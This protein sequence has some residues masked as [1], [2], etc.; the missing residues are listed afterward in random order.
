MN[1]ITIEMSHHELDY[2]PLSNNMNFSMRI[3]IFLIFI[4]TATNH[5][6]AC[7]CE[8]AGDFL[9]VAPE[10]K[11]V[12][13]VK[14]NRYLTFK[15]IYNKPTPMSMEV[16]IVE[17][18]KGEETRKFVTVWGNNG[19]LCRP[20]L[21]RFNIDNY[22]VIAFKQGSETGFNANKDEK[23]TD[24]AISNCGRYWLTADNEKE[25][26]TDAVSKNQNT[27]DFGDLRKYFKGDGSHQGERIKKNRWHLDTPHSTTFYYY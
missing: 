24:Y 21:S 16:E 1:K 12:A 18:F 17:I 9:T 11:L 4:L 22:Y 10:S 14:V 26:A 23:K 8:C 25:I 3:L 15:D 2:E 20:Y 6:F 27:I 13:L 7:D 5:I 19:G